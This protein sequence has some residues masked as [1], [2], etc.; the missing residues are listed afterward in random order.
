MPRAAPARMVRYRASIACTRSRAI[1]VSQALVG[2]MPFAHSV[3]L[4]YDRVPVGMTRIIG[5]S[6]PAAAFGVAAALH[7]QPLELGWLRESILTR[8]SD[9][10]YLHLLL[11]FGTVIQA[12]A[13]V[14][15]PSDDMLSVS[16]G[17]DSSEPKHP[18][19]P[20]AGL[21]LG[22]RPSGCLAGRA[23]VRLADREQERI[24]ERA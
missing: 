17:E 23:G 12:E 4:K 13:S 2:L 6:W 8:L 22:K 24:D 21:V 10:V 11:R 5:F 15:C 1:M 20:H 19:G 16:R 3:S 18:A 7:T 14:R 9:G